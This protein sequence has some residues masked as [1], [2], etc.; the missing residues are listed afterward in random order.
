[1][2]DYAKMYLGDTALSRLYQGDDLIWEKGTPAP[3]YD[4]TRIAVAL[5][6]END[7]P[8]D[9]VTYFET[10]AD[11]AA[12]LK[13]NTESRYLVSVG[14]E[15]QIE[16]IGKNAFHSCTSLAKL[17]IPATVLDLGEAAFGGCSN[18][19]EVK[20]IYGT[21]SISKQAFGGCASLREIV[22]PDSV[23]SIGGG[24]FSGCT[25]IENISLPQN[26]TILSGGLFGGCASL[27]EIVIPDS[28]T[29][30][31]GG[32][33]AGAGLS[34]ILISENVDSIGYNA[35]YMCDNLYRIIIN[36]P[37]NSISGAPWGATN[38]TVIWTG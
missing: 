28:V 17:R 22:I 38:A 16:E 3:S 5:L 8:T 15:T 1:M 37:E 12:Y 20:M 4:E 11:S 29:S 33:F 10:I 32:A 18:L 24:A 2:L 35:F 36:Q 14:S 26:L 27:H 30:I 34:E 19:L 25:K 13:N 6:D 7:E 9:N 31:G 23:T 21:I